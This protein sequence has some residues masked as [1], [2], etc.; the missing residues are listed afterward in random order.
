MTDWIA[1]TP[2]P[3]STA[4]AVA[5]VIDGAAG[6]IAVFMGTTRAET[7]PDG[8]QLLALD[9]DAYAEMAIEHLRRLV[10]TAR[11]NGEVTKVA[12]LHRLG[13]VAIGEPSVVIAVS[14]PHRAAAFDA[15]RFLIDQLKADVPIWKQERWDDGTGTWVHPGV[16]M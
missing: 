7:S 9:Y 11:A 1:L 6:G 16:K 15:C 3:L 5:F 13:R 12:L 2:H 14:T 8:R 4:D 10:A